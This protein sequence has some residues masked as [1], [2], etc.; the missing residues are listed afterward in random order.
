[1]NYTL[2]CFKYKNYY[3]REFR[4]LDTLAEF[5]SQSLG[6]PYQVQDKINNFNFSDGVM[7]SQVVDF[8]ASAKDYAVLVDEDSEIVARFYILECKYSRYNQYTL[9]LFRDLLYDYKTEIE[10]SVAFIEKGSVSADNPLIFNSEQMTFNQIKQ[11]QI[12][13]KDA[14]GC[15][16]IVAYLKKDYEGGEGVTVVRNSNVPDAF[17]GWA[18]YSLSN[19]PLAYMTAS[20]GTPVRPGIYSIR[21]AQYNATERRYR[22]ATRT[23][24]GIWTVKGD[25]AT[26]YFTAGVW[27]DF[28]RIFEDDKAVKEKI[29]DEIKSNSFSEDDVNTAHELNG[30]TI[31]LGNKYYKFSYSEMFGSR[32]IDAVEGTAFY[33]YVMQKA[34]EQFSSASSVGYPVSATMRAY[35]GTVTLEELSIGNLTYS[36]PEKGERTKT[37]DSAYDIICAPFGEFS[38]NNYSF[39]DPEAAMSVFQ[40]LA[41]DTGN[42]EDVQILPYCPNEYSSSS[43][44]IGTE[45]VRFIQEGSN[46]V[47]AIICVSKSSIKKTI[48]INWLKYPEFAP[49]TNKI[50]KKIQA[51]TDFARITNGSSIYEIGIAQNGGIGWIDISMTCLPITPY[52]KVSPR[53]GG[54]YGQT[55]EKEKRGLVLG[56]N[57]SIAYLSDPWKN[58][59][60]QNK[61]YSDIFDR[62][63]ESIELRNKYALAG[64]IL[65]AA[66]GAIGMAGK[67]ASLG[68]GGIGSIAGAAAGAVAGLATGAADVAISEKLRND[69]LELKKDLFGFQLGNIQ[70]APKTTARSTSYNV[71]SMY[72]PVLE[73]YTATDEEKEAFR[74]KIVYDG[75]TIGVIGKP[76]DY[77]DNFV[78]AVI[79]RCPDIAGDYGIIN[80]ISNELSKGVYRWE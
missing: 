35:F 27:L 20:G 67:G 62:E 53:F 60:N 47:G 54:L 7:T 39:N 58:F 11:S 23:A 31:K 49:K 73:Y 15:P 5:L 77:F 74:N 13:L 9:E 28:E 46:V 33:N 25:I 66:T 40:D 17:T 29:F 32:D 14:T 57:F 16:W 70:A 24:G 50:E 26:A 65:G 22:T 41:G 51:M 44:S 76:F 59:V 78:K 80:A 45:D 55:F 69:S 71:D 3:N 75:M 21:T 18:S 8:D 34:R 4:S 64:D 43:A 6:L 63:V 37:E 72:F 52:I 42:I 56:G 2:Y 38:V 10:N 36:I 1:M 30:R 68:G 79:I 61:N 19:F 48:P 12:P